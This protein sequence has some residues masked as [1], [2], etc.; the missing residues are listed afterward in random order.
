LHFEITVCDAHRGTSGYQAPNRQGDLP[1]QLALR[2]NRHAVGE[3]RSRETVD[4]DLSVFKNGGENVGV[5][6]VRYSLMSEVLRTT[7]GDLRMIER[8]PSCTINWKLSQYLIDE[9]PSLIQDINET[10]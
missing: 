6:I 8:R 9:I 1:H 4:R 10:Q 5:P 2:S 3:S 7:R